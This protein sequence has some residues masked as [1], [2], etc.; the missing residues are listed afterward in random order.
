[1]TVHR[2]R[3]ILLVCSS[4]ASNADFS[5]FVLESWAKPHRLPLLEWQ[6]GFPG[7][8]ADSMLSGPL[9]DLTT[10]VAASRAGT[11]HPCFYNF[12]MNRND[13]IEIDQTP[14]KDDTAVSDLTSSVNQMS[15]AKGRSPWHTIEA[16]RIQE[17]EDPYTSNISEF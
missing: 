15:V 2:S 13:V 10:K 7:H 12:P 5:A 9:P 14:P 4:V 6:R 17:A 3:E 16:P 8:A 11:E 1:M